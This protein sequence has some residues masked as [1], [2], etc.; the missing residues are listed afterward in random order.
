MFFRHKTSPS[1][2]ALQLLESYRDPQ[3]QPRHRVVVSL[4]DAALAQTDWKPVAA[5]VSARLYGQ[6]ELALAGLWPSAQRWADSI[7][8]RVLREGRWLPLRGVVA[9]PHGESLDGVLVDEITHAQHALLGPVWLGQHA[10]E[11]LE[12][13]AALGKLGFNRRQQALAAALVI[14]RLAEPLSEHALVDWLAGTALPELLGESILKGDSNR[15]YYVGDALLRRQGELERHWRGQQARHFTYGRTILLYDLT[16]THFEGE[17]L[18][19]PKARR[20]RNKQG[21]DDCPQVVVGVVYDE[22]G[23]ELAHRTFAG[24]Q[25][26]S[27]S[28]VEMVEAL[29]AA[30]GHPAGRELLPPPAVMVIVDAGVATAKNL[31]L[32]AEANFHYLVNDTRRGRGKWR[33]EFAQEDK[34]EP[35][36]GRENKSEVKVRAVA[37][38]AGEQVVLC[39]SQGRRQKELA[40]RSRAEEKFLAALGKLHARL[41]KGQL[42]D[43]VKA[44]RALGRLLERSARVGRFYQVELKAPTDLRAGL[45]WQRKDAAY[46]QDEELLGCYVLRSDRSDLSA[47][48]LWEL[49]VLLARAED[50]FRALKGDLGLRPNHHQ[51]EPRVDGHIFITMMAYQLLRFITYT[52]EQKG[53]PRDWPTVRRVLETHGYATVSVPTRSG[54]VVH[55]RRPGAPDSCQQEIYAKFGMDWKKLPT[56]KITTAMKSAT[57]L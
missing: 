18:G 7:A 54:T 52:L 55:L 8:R 23:F 37:A 6:P 4:G 48:R 12:F 43:Q 56:K 50:G 26:D 2:R 42:K 39:K 17:A 30:A 35:L 5:V 14:N 1:G 9:E 57:T 15:F 46:G 13:P 21:R 3:G 53:D 45:S 16:N 25:S 40:M 49:Y 27:Q 10:W 33:A 47:A 38:K 41:E 34:F 36:A 19:N 29:Q 32:L 51:V 11:A 31:K 24:N 20:G 28:L 22:Q 44:Q